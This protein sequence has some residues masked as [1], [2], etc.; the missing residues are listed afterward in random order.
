MI[1]NA[2]QPKIGLYKT[3]FEAVLIADHF[4]SFFVYL[5]F[6]K[7][8]FYFKNSFNLESKGRVQVF[9]FA[10]SRYIK[11]NSSQKVFFPHGD[12]HSNH[13][14]HSSLILIK[15]YIESVQSSVAEL[16]TL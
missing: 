12:K 1:N 11:P 6:A 15:S 4:Y 10:K 13:Y 7:A 2:K 16:L 9:H 5:D 8:I 14:M 3:F